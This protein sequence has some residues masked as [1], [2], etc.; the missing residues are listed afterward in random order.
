MINNIK[1]QLRTGLCRFGGYTLFALGLAGVF[2]PL[3]PT[4]IF[5][6]AAA[7]LFTRAHPEM[8]D[9]I[10]A[11]PHFGSIV[12][13]LLEEGVLSA[14]SKH[15]ATLGITIVGGLSVAFS[16]IPFLWASVVAAVLM[17]VII[18]IQTRPEA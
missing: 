7:W 18:Y 12:E 13:G 15:V 2:L 10:Y 1:T 16:P 4:T 6:I 3:L 9:K 14:R 11:W 8:K 5:W 17:L